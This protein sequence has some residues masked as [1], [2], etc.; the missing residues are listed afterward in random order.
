[1]SVTRDR[2]LFVGDRRV[3]YQLL[4]ERVQEQLGPH[5]PSVALRADRHLDYG[6]VLV[7]IDAIR[8]AGVENVGLIV[9]PLELPEG[10]SPEDAADEGS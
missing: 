9:N 4:S 5:A 1:M 3:P 6:Y 8:R 10:A 7:V 2:K